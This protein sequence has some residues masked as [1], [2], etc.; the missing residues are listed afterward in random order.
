M[1][2]LFGKQLT[3][4]GSKKDISPAFAP[5]DRRSKK[6]REIRTLTML[7]AQSIVD[8]CDKD[9]LISSYRIIVSVGIRLLRKLPRSAIVLTTHLLMLIPQWWWKPQILPPHYQA[10]FD[11]SESMLVRWWC[12]LSFARR[13][14]MM[15]TSNYSI[16]LRTTIPEP[17]QPW[18]DKLDW[19]KA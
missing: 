3:I 10:L 4:P 2:V 17:Y 9:L 5:C 11:S 12:R 13:F 6:R 18:I 14:S 19:G 16:E 15:L 8:Y 7:N 1:M